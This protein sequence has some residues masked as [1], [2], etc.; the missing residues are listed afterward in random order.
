MVFSKR[1][2]NSNT[3]LFVL[4]FS[5]LI[6]LFG[7]FLIGST[8]EGSR[9][10]VFLGDD[11]LG[12]NLQ[13]GLGEF[14]L[15]K[16]IEVTGSCSTHADC[17]AAEFC[18]NSNCAVIQ[19][20]KCLHKMNKG[21]GTELGC[22]DI[23]D[24]SFCTASGCAWSGTCGFTG[25]S[26]WC[27]DAPSQGVCDT[28]T[29]GVCQWG[30]PPPPVLSTF[31]HTFDGTVIDGGLFGAQVVEKNLAIAQNNELQ[32][33][34]TSNADTAVVNLPTKNGVGTAK[35]FNLTLDITFNPTVAGGPVVAIL[36]VADVT[37]P[38]GCQITKNNAGQF[39][40]CTMSSKGPIC[41]GVSTGTGNLRFDW[42]A[43]SK[44]VV[45]SFDGQIATVNGVTEPVGPITIEGVVP[46][47]GDTM[48]FNSDNLDYKVGSNGI[49]PPPPT[50]TDFLRPFNGGVIDGTFFA[51]PVVEKNLVITQNNQLQIG[52]TSNADTAIAI[53]TTLQNVNSMNQFNLSADV[54]F[55]ATSTGAPI[56]ADMI[57]NHPGIP[58]GC[59]L[60]KDNAGNFQ[61]CAVSS[62]AAVCKGVS[63]GTGKLEM[64]WTAGVN[65]L[66]CKF[67]GNGVDVAGVNKPLG[68]ILLGAAVPKSGDT[69]QFNV[70]NLDLKMGGP[71][72]IPPAGCVGHA[73]CADAQ[74]CVSGA[75]IPWAYPAC[76]N[77]SRGRG[78]ELICAE[79]DDTLC[80]KSGCNWNGSACLFSGYS[81]W[82][83]N[84]T[85]QPDCDTE[86][87]GVCEWFASPPVVPTVYLVPYTDDFAGVGLN[88]SVYSA[89]INGLTLTKNEKVVA[90]G[91][92]S[93]DMASAGAK[94]LAFLNQTTAFNISVDINVTGQSISVDQ[95]IQGAILKM[96]PNARG[97]YV[98]QN[99]VGAYNLCTIADG[100]KVC[101]GVSKGVGKLKF[102]WNP[103]TH[104]KC[105]FDGQEVVNSNAAAVGD[106]SLLLTAMI[107]KTGDKGD[108]TFDNLELE[109]NPNVVLVVP[110]AGLLPF[111]E[112]FTGA[113]INLTRFNKV[114]AGGLAVGQSDD[115]E[116]M[117]TAGA[118]NTVAALETKEVLNI[119]SIFNVSANINL[120]GV[121]VNNKVVARLRDKGAVNKNG[122]Q[123][124]LNSSGAYQLCIRYNN[125]LKGNCIAVPDGIGRLTY[126]WNPTGGGVY[127]TLDGLQTSRVGVV[128][129]AGAIALDLVA[130][131]TGDF[132]TVLFDNLEL[133]YLGQMPPIPGG[134]CATDDNCVVGEGCDAGICRIKCVNPNDCASG[135]VCYQAKFCKSGLLPFTEAFTGTTINAGLFNNP[136]DASGLTTTQNNVLI[137]S[138]TAAADDVGI[139][140]DTKSY[141]DTSSNFELSADFDFTATD[142]TDEFSFTLKLDDAGGDTIGCQIWAG[143]DGQ[144]GTEVKDLCTR[145]KN[146]E[147]DDCVTPN[148]AKSGKLILQWDKQFNRLRCIIGSDSVEGYD[149]TSPP[150]QVALTF[151]MKDEDDQGKVEVDNLEYKT[152]PTITPPPAPEIQVKNFV[153]PFQSGDSLVA[154]GNA[155]LKGY[156]GP[157]D[158][159]FL[160]YTSYY[161][162]SF[163]G[164]GKLRIVGTNDQATDTLGVVYRNNQVYYMPFQTS[165]DIDLKDT[166][167]NINGNT[168]VI[169]GLA[170]LDSDLGV[171][172]EAVLTE[173]SQ[174]GVVLWLLDADGIV[175]TALL[176]SSNGVLG[177]RVNNQDVAEITFKD[178]IIFTFEDFGLS[179]GYNPSLFYQV[180]DTQNAANTDGAI[181]ITFDNWNFMVQTEAAL[182]CSSLDSEQCQTHPYCY[183]RDMGEFSLCEEKECWDLPNQNDCSDSQNKIGKVCDW[184]ASSSSFDGW[185]EM[186]SCYS[187]EGTNENTCVN[188]ADG[189][190]CD[191]QES[192]S[193]WKEE[194]WSVTD[195]STCNSMNGCFWGMCQEQGCWNYG[196]ITSC[197]AP[198][199]KGS[200]GGNCKW[201]GGQNYCYEDSCWNIETK[202]A[203]EASA[204]NCEYDD[205]YNQCSEVSCSSYDYTSTN[206]CETAVG[207]TCSYDSNTNRCSFIDCWDKGE[208]ACGT[209][210]GCSW[211]AV[212]GNTGGECRDVDCWDLNTRA[213]CEAKDECVFDSIRNQCSRGEAKTCGG[214]VN[215][216]DCMD[217]RHCYW[218]YDTTTCMDPNDNEYTSIFSAW[219]PG[220]YIF[221]DSTTCAKASG[222][223]YDETD[224]CITKVGHDNEA[225]IDANGLACSYI[226]DLDLCTSISSLSTCCDWVGTGCAASYDPKCRTEREELPQNLVKCSDAGAVTSDIKAAENLCSQ[227]AGSPWFAPC[228][229]DSS[230]GQCGFNGDSVFGDRTQS[231]SLI[232]N[233]EM[234]KFGGGKWIDEFYCEGDDSMPAG[235]CEA[236]G[237]EENNCNVACFACESGF[238]GSPHTTS[239]E[240]SEYCFDSDLGYCEPTLD[241]TAPNG[242]GYCSAK[243]EFKNKVATDC[244]SDCG[245]C[246]YM[247]NPNAASP[248]DGSESYYS[249]N[250]PQCYCEN[251]DSFGNVNCKYVSDS[252]S[253]LGGYCVDS[254]TKTCQDSCDRCYTQDECVNDGKNVWGVSGLCSWS[255]TATDGSCG[256]AGGGNDE[257]CWDA[258]DNDENG[259]IDC[260]D[261]KCFTDPSCGFVSVTDNC[262]S[263]TTVAT[264]EAAGCEAI[265][266]YGGFFCDFAGARCWEN[267]GDSTA[268]TNAGCEF[269][270]G[271][272][273]A[274]ASCEQ[275][276]GSEMTCMEAE[277]DDA[278]GGLDGCVFESDDWC[279][280]PEGAESEWCADGKAG[281]CKSE[282]FSDANV[283]CWRFKATNTCN[284]QDGCVFMASDHGETCE[285]DWSVDCPS[286]TDS[287]SCIS[288][289]CDWA[290]EDGYS[291]CRGK[292]EKCFRKN[293]R[294]QCLQDSDI[295]DWNEWGNYCDPICFSKENGE[296][297]AVDGCLLTSGWCEQDWSGSGLSCFDL[298]EEG[299]CNSADGCTYKG[300]GW[301]SPPGFTGGSAFDEG[302]GGG[303]EMGSICWK[304]DGT[305]Q[306]A[307]ESNADGADCSWYQEI[308]PYCDVDWSGNCWE[309]WDSDSC[310]ATGGCTWNG[311]ASNCESTFDQCWGIEDSGTCNTNAN[312]NYNVLGSYCE[313]ICFSLSAG[314]CAANDDCK[315]MSGWCEAP[316]MGAMFDGMESGMPVMVAMDECGSETSDHLDL[317][318][319]GVKDMGDA[320]GFGGIVSNMGDAGVCNNKKIGFDGV[321]VGNGDEDLK[322]YVYI[323]SDG[324]TDGGC[325]LSDDNSLKGYEFMLK[326]VSTWNDDNSKVEDTFTSYKCV[327]SKWKVADISLSAWDTKMCSEIGGPI[328]AVQKSDLEKF[329]ALYNS[330]VD[331][332]VSVATAGDGKDAS[333]PSDTAGPGWVTPGAFDFEL[334]GF[335]DYGVDSAQFEDIMKNGY[336]E[337]EDCFNSIDDDN[338]GSVDCDDWDC[339]E[340]KMC[341]N[342][343]V[344]AAGY[345]DN[346][347]PKISGIKVEEYTDSVMVM[348]YSDKPTTG[349][350]YDYGTDSSCTGPTT[351]IYD[352]GIISDNMKDYKM[353]HI[354]EVYDDGGV[355]SLDSPLT[356]DTDYYYKLEIC[357]KAGK[358]AKSK[359][360]KVRTSNGRCPYCKFVTKIVAP[361][362]WTVSYD[363]NTDGTYEHIQGTVCGTN[364]G[365]KTSYTEGRS[366]NV[367]ISD[368]S[369]YKMI[370]NDVHLTKTGLTSDT[371]DIQSE[372][373]LIATTVNDVPLVGMASSTRD[374]I[375][376]NLHPDS[377]QIRIPSS[378]DCSEL[379]HCDDSGANCLVRDDATLVLDESSV[380]FCTWQIPYCEFSTWA[381]G[382]AGSAAPVSS[383]DGGAS[384]GSG[385][386]G[387]TSAVAEEEEEEETISDFIIG[388]DEGMG[389]LFEF[390][391]FEITPLEFKTPEGKEGNW[392]FELYG[393]WITIG[394]LGVL[395]VL[396]IVVSRVRR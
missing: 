6:F 359:C 167:A 176:D 391:D 166:S 165:V 281:W 162:P 192:C 392:F 271:S 305:N 357:D 316:G 220:C 365:M 267:D 25:T 383:S 169:G 240:F 221:S 74:V 111:S 223:V 342:L 269:S 285:V 164:D 180:I 81:P 62:K 174:G 232:D 120:T 219:S 137:M 129:G 213:T 297:E 28:N 366:A 379:W 53:I 92:A 323:D 206:T 338:D 157:G 69:V 363:L 182:D 339:A 141:V 123:L 9:G 256:S 151:Y 369:G 124:E 155:K 173:D 90:G 19:Y 161:N 355:N 275:D 248:F 308:K 385:G 134:A 3:Y 122:C 46:T 170:I 150:A 94:T 82:C 364:A 346:S 171:L 378:P 376:N 200:R 349:T 279:N 86:T 149:R 72:V 280:Q 244:K 277:D 345:V 249:C 105:Q 198:G 333:D 330:G 126:L 194:C 225:A 33:S 127:C 89:A 312:C 14:L 153:I 109:I 368:T 102:I 307:C 348:Y 247:G 306:N 362:G 71:G 382:D 395:S 293:S 284:A 218:D 55:T 64:L 168:L 78:S 233:E 257:V 136:V 40:L 104:I 57:I 199:T 319:I 18:D 84:I 224:G 32:M 43:G 68:P 61:L 314:D 103:N 344:N 125:G 22:A 313:P 135:K 268:C 190:I 352:K 179:G 296:C 353:W 93:K 187:Y 203:C 303:G 317:C 252:D 254:T 242:F 156:M 329:P 272:G 273:D 209:A 215:E 191:W 315:L 36:K 327:S 85:T 80:A 88:I 56:S 189:L 212:R 132:S 66:G 229:W 341:E 318:G 160:L 360:S 112:E 47:S 262:P 335:F 245:S 264:C 299:A 15:G 324:S 91:T 387:G 234:C 37:N 34:G 238:D 193:G 239:Q 255:G 204:M 128:G 52:G 196:D 24:S 309:K 12:L 291:W 44:N 186:S 241:S 390:G 110:P 77:S 222:C 178:N 58:T 185:C 5:L 354:A 301:C 251:T 142:I 8:V 118:P 133:T 216:M 163:T 140:V 139:E 177:F 310:G 121:T 4:V 188:N 95:F 228:E 371:R 63:T 332:R 386:A 39:Q 211:Q 230:T 278:C 210:V 300:A 201:D 96:G 214:F 377:C 11:S 2:G 237:D 27:I 375:I 325:A 131:D 205:A 154:T 282:T 73:G 396:Y 159:P 113:V 70:D 138:G 295:C 101:T 208:S 334:A 152:D 286:L 17:S 108:V 217:T 41:K 49:V 195:S 202:T 381:G 259:E 158:M 289:G 347:A 384:G 389:N 358:C 100:P 54:V 290:E 288:G 266:D 38:T 320:L 146:D 337:Y 31:L 350:Y 59:Q 250:T 181:D 236:K 276:W 30:S 42:I 13:G 380:G 172:Y 258:I 372:G 340:L 148:D 274:S 83:V 117:G 235:R 336:V 331:M 51:L 321:V 116:I 322:F 343:G 107:G 263:F 98:S 144:G 26:P 106:N 145:F 260:G 298:T 287:S 23:S 351:S 294:E 328:I 231:L 115:L 388:D 45:C 114:E 265:E 97:C 367:M 207:L 311:G 87:S 246:T 302:T 326:Y 60:R 67:D 20:P 356:A 243:E 226:T 370:F 119:N 393:L 373:A 361:E 7:F 270:L 21:K 374:K 283:E 29:N 147:D 35:H 227:V 50:L 184:E 253:D 10:M 65:N 394:I 292:F 1:G 48:L 183:Y 79:L 304:Y 16:V 175:D 76:L 130:S 143:D 197:T 75:C 261:A 99:N